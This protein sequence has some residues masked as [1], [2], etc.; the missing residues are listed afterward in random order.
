MNPKLY[1]RPIAQRDSD[2]LADW[3][4]W[5]ADCR[6]DE[7]VAARARQRSL[8]QQACQEST[9]TGVLLDL[10]ERGRPVTVKTAGGRCCHGRIA[11]VGAD[12]VLVCDDNDDRLLIP[13]ASIATISTSAAQRRVTGARL[14]PSVVLAE[15]IHDLAADQARIKVTV[16]GECVSGLLTTAGADVIAVAVDQPQEDH[17]HVATAA[18]DHL[19]VLAR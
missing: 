14:R 2:V 1:R 15:V 10:G 3:S 7:A 5:L 19:V 18:I 13:T 12:F 8:E 4:R 17:L 6:V 9:I 11:A 16:A